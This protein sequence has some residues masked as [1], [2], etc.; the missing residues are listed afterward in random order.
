MGDPSRYPDIRTARLV[1]ALK[2]LPRDFRDDGF[3]N[4]GARGFPSTPG[5]ICC[6]A[7]RSS[8]ASA[9]RFTPTCKT[10]SRKQG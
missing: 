6:L 3:G 1:Y 5:S 10:C 4:S 8:R 7:S 2:W 9:R